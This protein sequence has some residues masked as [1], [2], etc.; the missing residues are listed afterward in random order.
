VIGGT[1]PGLPLVVIGRNE[2]IAWGLTTTHSDTQD[3]FVERLDPE[4]PE[5]YLAPGGPRAFETREEVI[6]LKGGGEERLT[7]R[8][9]RNGPVISDLAMVEAG[10]VLDDG[11]VLAL[12]WTA[13]ADDDLTVQAGFRIMTA[14]SWEELVAALADYAAPQQNVHYADI[15]GRI[16]FHAPGRV[17]MRR[18]GD[19]TLPVPGWTGEHDWR[20]L[21]PFEELP[22][23]VSPPDGRLLNANNRIVGDHY[24]HLITRHWP[25]ALR[26]RR[27]AEL[28]EAT[29]H[30]LADSMAMQQDEVSLLARDFVPLFLELVDGQELD[31]RAALA[32]RMLAGWDGTM[33]AD[34]PEPLIFAAWYEQVRRHVYADELGPLFEDMRGLRPAFLMRALTERRV[35]CNDV[36]TVRVETCGERVAAALLAALD[37][38]EALHGDDMASWRW[39][40]AHRVE[41]D[42]EVLR[43][44]PVIGRLAGIGFESGGHGSTLN[45]LHTTGD[46]GRPFVSRMG[47]TLRMVVDLAEPER[48]RFIATTGQSGHPLSRHYRDHAQLWRE[49]AYLPMVTDP[50]RYGRGALGTLELRPR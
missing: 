4:D 46:A 50:A 43:F 37:Q 36:D 25:P 33:A 45:A 38:L 2:R 19:G 12:A 11:H 24:P 44:L 8:R 28:L 31:G 7:V 18:A 29:P 40:A 32:A 21:V 27:I 14:G 47:P 48:S 10:E 41:M 39:G 42:H 6:R 13:L 15:D 49:G 1:M 26:A 20:G 22:H 17:P 16:G 9:T 5:R 23:A 35:W 3:L 34:R 30:D